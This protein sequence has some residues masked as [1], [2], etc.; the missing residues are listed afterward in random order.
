M[1]WDDCGGRVG[2]TGKFT[3]FMAKIVQKLFIFENFLSW[4]KQENYVR[5]K[6]YK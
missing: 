1:M 4:G 3:N 2:C 6:R 5:G